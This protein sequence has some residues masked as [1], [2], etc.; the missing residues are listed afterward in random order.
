MRF[1]GPMGFARRCV[2]YSAEFLSLSLRLAVSLPPREKR[3]SCPSAYSAYVYSI[4]TDTRVCGRT[5]VRVN[6]FMRLCS[7]GVEAREREHARRSETNAPRHGMVPTESGR[8]VKGD[9]VLSR[10]PAPPSPAFLPASPAPFLDLLFSPLP[11]SLLPPLSLS[12][13][14]P[15]SLSLSLSLSVC[16]SLFLCFFVSPFLRRALDWIL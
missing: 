14:L 16:L 15:L 10:P 12:L 6:A 1:Y 7:A 4:Q 13:S 2:P 11:L 3:R 8:R 5:Y 9:L